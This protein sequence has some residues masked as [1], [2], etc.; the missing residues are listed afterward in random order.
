MQ[1]LPQQFYVRGANLP[2]TVSGEIINEVFVNMRNNALIL[3]N[4]D[5]LERDI[6][7][8]FPDAKQSLNEA[9]DNLDCTY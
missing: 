3:H 6:E 5:L 1:L 2:H 8:S 4:Q 9:K 7:T